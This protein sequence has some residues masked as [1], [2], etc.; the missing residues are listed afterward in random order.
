N[1]TLLFDQAYLDNSDNDNENQFLRDQYE[2]FNYDILLDKM[3]QDDYKISEDLF[4][5]DT[6][7]ENLTQEGSH[8]LSERSPQESFNILSEGSSQESSNALS[9]ESS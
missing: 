7:S 3:S 6:I 5:V 1:Q 8:L 4:Q 9:E 2:N